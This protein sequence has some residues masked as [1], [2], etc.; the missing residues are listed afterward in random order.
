MFKNAIGIFFP[1]RLK[2]KELL[3]PRTTPYVILFTITSFMSCE[4]HSQWNE[5][6]ILSVQFYLR[7]YDLKKNLSLSCYGPNKTLKLETKT[8][9]NGVYIIN[10][11]R[12]KDVV[13][14]KIVVLITIKTMI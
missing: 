4:I 5:T 12:G 8:L 3:Y 1:R 10:F 11:E 7:I 14:K 2:W 6:K 9:S 13:S